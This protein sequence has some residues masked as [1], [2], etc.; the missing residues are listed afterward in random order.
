MTSLSLVFT[1]MGWQQRWWQQPHPSSGCVAI[2]VPAVALT[3]L[4]QLW[5]QWC[6]TGGGVCVAVLVVTAPTPQCRRRRPRISPG[7]GDCMAVPGPGGGVCPAVPSMATA[8]QS[9]QWLRPCRGC[10][11]SLVPC[12]S[13]HLFKW[14]ISNPSLGHI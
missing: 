5:L 1:M 7:G 13:A 8:Q 9:Q 12:L 14:E 4:P 6:S 11:N 3:S 10:G 2:L